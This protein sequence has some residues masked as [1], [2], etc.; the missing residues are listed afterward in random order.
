MFALDIRTQLLSFTLCN[1]VCLLVVFSLWRHNSK[2]YAGTHWWMAT[3]LLQFLGMLLLFA[4]GV[5]PDAFSI[6]LA[7][8][9]LVGGAYLLQRGLT[10]FLGRR[11]EPWHGALLWLVFVG[12]HAYFS[13]VESNVHVRNLNISLVLAF[14]SGEMALMLL[15][16]TPAAQR[17]I[18]AMAGWTLA[19]YMLF[20]LVR[21]AMEIKNPTQGSYVF[22]NAQGV[23]VALV[24]QLLCLA[25]TFSLSLMV[26]R[27]L[28]ANL[29]EQ[30]ALQEETT[31]ALRHSESRFKLAERYA[32]LGHWQLDLRT[33]RV[34]LSEGAAAIYELDSNDVHESDVLA[35]VPPGHQ[36]LIRNQLRGLMSHGREFNVTFKT[37]GARTGQAKSINA[38]AHF[39]AAHDRVFGVVQDVSQL[40]QVEEHLRNTRNQ[41]H[42]ILDASPVAVRI[43][44]LATHTI[45]YA[46][47]SY[48]ALTGQAPGAIVGMSPRNAYVNK[49]EYQAIHDQVLA[50]QTI[51][52]RLMEVHKV[53][54]HLSLHDDETA[55]T[56]WL[57]ASYA[58]LQ[59]K[60]DDC[61]IAWLYDVSDLQL[62]RAAAEEANSSKSAFLANMSHEI[63]TPL[64]AIVG[65]SYILRTTTLTPAQS[66]S[67]AT[68]ESA[69]SHLIQIIND[70]LDLSKIEAGKITLEARVFRLSVLMNNVVTMLKDRALARG[71][72]LHTRLDLD[73]LMY[74]GDP[75]RL[76]QVL[77]NYGSNAIKFSSD[78][79]VHFHVSAQEEK[80]ETTVLRF[81]VSDQGIGIAP[82]KVG[83]LFSAFEQADVSTTRK[84][85]GTGLGLAISK[86]IATLMGGEVGVTS[87]PGVGST[88]WFTAELERV[89]DDTELD[90]QSWRESLKDQ[91]KHHFAGTKV[92]VADDEPVNLEIATFLLEEV[93]FMVEQADDGEQALELARTQ[94]FDMVILDMQM[95]RRDGL[96]TSRALRGM[97]RYATLPI[98]AMTGNIFKEDRERCT[99]AGM[100]AFVPKPIEQLDF[101][102]VLWES[103]MS[104]RA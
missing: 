75:T 57:R 97:P 29:N 104:R 61:E 86:N 33:R 42:H 90:S 40:R 55:D 66:Q 72:R 44:N 85:G 98:I 51:T 96:S 3:F 88:F 21:V 35:N 26:N 48:C 1:L 49:A 76:Q 7:N 27:S 43:V 56:M 37:L 47:N 31:D 36:A 60:D 41:L 16:Q 84:Y 32:R 103:C 53:E 87:A 45:A 69:S 52:N 73:H 100:S 78:S 89:P 65:M 24:Y 91:I 71:V 74:L 70:V 9:M 4:R 81:A 10:Q 20:S 94:D 50:G 102:Q 67:I 82:E 17:P 92:L 101:Y 18:T 63:R 8:A 68:M 28:I 6:V 15:W 77:L 11:F 99:A 14:L 62:A 25:M 13:L 58:P 34:T 2:R 80:D 64:N 93:G 23:F 12:V 79:D 54:G 19:T 39:D 22:G 30:L 83:R 59:Y 46:N 95:P 38:I 5:V